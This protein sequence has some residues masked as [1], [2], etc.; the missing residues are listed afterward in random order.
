MKKWTE[1]EKAFVISN[2]DNMTYEEMTKHLER[3]GLAIKGI[4]QR[5]R[6]TNDR[7]EFDPKIK[8]GRLTPIR[9]LY[10]DHRKNYWLCV[11][12]CGKEV[13]TRS[14]S[15]LSGVT[16]SCGCYHAKTTAKFKD[17][18]GNKYG[19]L[20][21]LGFHKR[22]KNRYLWNCVCECS[23]ET[24]VSRSHLKSGH[25]QSCGNCGVFVNGKL[26]SSQ[27]RAIAEMI[28]GVLNHRQELKYI[29]VA[30][31]DKKIAIEYDG[32]YWHQGNEQRD[33]QR[34]NELLDSGWRVLVVKSSKKIP[35][36][37]TVIQCLKELER[38][39]YV[40]LILDDWK[41]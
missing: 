32:W 37:K 7:Q 9:F 18:T 4:A 5:L 13:K 8:Y 24:I 17:I 1:D 34:T 11:C 16:R 22:K 12:D 41:S 10:E 35:S 21:V 3:T 25:T 26:T 38:T 30:L 14:S 28:S 15:L 27:Q 19:K 23:K 33:K 36:K 40:E 31:P 6:I 20:T 39:N 29:D 2:Y